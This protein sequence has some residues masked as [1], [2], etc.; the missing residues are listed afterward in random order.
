MQTLQAGH[1]EKPVKSFIVRFFQQSFFN[2]FLHPAGTR[3]VEIKAE[4]K[5]GALKVAQYHFFLSGGNF[6]VVA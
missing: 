1:I 4:T 6:E 3:E 5:E 2:V